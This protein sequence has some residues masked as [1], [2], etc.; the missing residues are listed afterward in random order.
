MGVFLH[1]RKQAMIKLP[2][3][4]PPSPQCLSLGVFCRFLNYFRDYYFI[5]GVC[6][7]CLV[8]FQVFSR[9]LRYHVWNIVVFFLTEF[10]Q[11]CQNSTHYE[12]R[13]T[14][15]LGSSQRLWLEVQEKQ[16]PLTACKLERREMCLPRRLYCGSGYRYYE[17]KFYF[18]EERGWHISF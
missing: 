9:P 8:K 2:P 12:S 5:K 4:P 1:V 6:T 18:A 14:E 7:H 10:S 15:R 17:T 16:T 13:V 11:P 3:T